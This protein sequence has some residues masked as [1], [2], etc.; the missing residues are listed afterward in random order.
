M[1][2]PDLKTQYGPQLS[3]RRPRTCFSV[4]HDGVNGPA[5]DAPLGL[6]RGQSANEQR[7]INGSSLDIEGKLW[8]EIGQI[9]K[10][11]KVQSATRQLES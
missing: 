5:R 1:N 9:S 8:G 6:R 10:E 3:L 7:K 2:C 4:D 11:G